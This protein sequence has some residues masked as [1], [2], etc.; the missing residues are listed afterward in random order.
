MGDFISAI[1]LLPVL[2]LCFYAAER[3]INHF[4]EKRR[5]KEKMRVIRMRRRELAYELSR[6]A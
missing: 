3:V 5:R 6:C 1:A 4:V 2:C